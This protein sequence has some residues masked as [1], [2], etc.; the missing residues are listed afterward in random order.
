MSQPQ[1]AARMR[2]LSIPTLYLL[3]SRC[4]NL[5]L[6]LYDDAIE[7]AASFSSGTGQGIECISTLTDY[8]CTF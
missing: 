4:G 7:R 8:S 3:M 6:W 2:L 5:E 1:S